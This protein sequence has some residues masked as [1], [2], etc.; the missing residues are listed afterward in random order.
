M[1]LDVDPSYAVVK[2]K[3]QTS[4]SR[5]KAG[6]LANDK[7]WELWLLYNFHFLI[8]G[9]KWRTVIQH[10]K[11]TSMANMSQG[12][13]KKSRCVSDNQGADCSAAES[14]TET[15]KAEA[16]DKWTPSKLDEPDAGQKSKTIV[17][18]ISSDIRR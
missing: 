4:T 3:R 8:I 18:F 2:W 12:L 14:T 17:F 5:F 15:S 1:D 9:E 10:K 11:E 13:S 16:L 6:Q 7:E